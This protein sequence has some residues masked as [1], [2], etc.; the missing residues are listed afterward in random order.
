M[1]INSKLYK[2]EL[3]ALLVETFEKTGGFYLDPDTSLFD[4]LDAVTAEQASRHDPSNDETAAGHL[5][6]LTFYLDVL[7]EYT[8]GARTGKTD[9]NES[10]TVKEVTEDK[11]DALKADARRGYD[12]SLELVRTFHG[13]DAEKFVSGTLAILAHSA[14]HLGAIRQ[15]LD[16]VTSPPTVAD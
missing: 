8:T 14:F 12:D 9:W 2:N 5:Y 11:W 10:W 4:T 3:V 13:D 7:R 16:R 6:H 1:A 15:I